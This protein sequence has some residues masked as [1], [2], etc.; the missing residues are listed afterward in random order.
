MSDMK[1]PRFGKLVV[2]VNGLVPLAML[3]WDALRGR[4]GAN[5][6]EYALHTA[7]MVALVMLT[8]SLCVTPVRKVT[9]WNWL[10]HFRRTLGLLAFFYGFLHLLLYAGFEREYDI[11]AIVSDTLKR[12]FIF[13]GMLA[14]LLMVPLAVT[15]T[16]E[17]VKRLGAKVWKRLHKLAYV[18]AVAGVVHYWMRVKADTSLP[19]AFAVTLGILFAYR[20][21]DAL[22][23]R[24]TQSLASSLS[25]A[26]APA[27]AP[28]RSV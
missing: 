22:R 9:G 16:N 19:L 24:R 27:A 14:F 20:V 18:A 25:S 8:L 5:P 4:L 13:F 10:S 6:I 11:S 17:S 21:F 2:L 26:H 15:S 28:A 1:D 7:G 23:P 3:L 12:P